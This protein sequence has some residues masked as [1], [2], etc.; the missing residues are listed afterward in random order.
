MRRDGIGVLHALK[1]SLLIPIKP[2]AFQLN[3]VK[4][5]DFLLYIFLFHGLVS[6]P[7]G[8]RLIINSINSGAFIKESLFM[9][10]LFL[11]ILFKMILSYPKIRKKG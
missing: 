10:V 7:N 1:L 8:A 4:T 2:V 6:F 9:L 5:K 3:R 11:M